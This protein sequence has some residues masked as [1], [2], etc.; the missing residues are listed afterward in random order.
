MSPRFD[1]FVSGVNLGNE[2]AGRV[3]DVLSLHQGWKIFCELSLDLLQAV[4]KC[5]ECALELG[6][7]VG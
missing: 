5:R 1:H 2:E 4:E 3:H 6:W 7:G